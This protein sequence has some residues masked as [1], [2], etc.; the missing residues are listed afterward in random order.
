MDSTWSLTEHLDG[1]AGQWPGALSGF[2]II[3][4]EQNARVAAK[5]WA[6]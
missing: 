2:D 6:T 5:L 3:F 4:V 1:F